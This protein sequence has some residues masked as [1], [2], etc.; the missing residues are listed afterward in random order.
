MFLF[1][2]LKYLFESIVQNIKGFK[3]ILKNSFISFFFFQILTYELD[4]L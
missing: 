2:I 3:Y 1:F 4:Y